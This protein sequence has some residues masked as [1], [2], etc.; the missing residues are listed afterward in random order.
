MVRAADDAIREEAPDWDPDTREWWAVALEDASP[1]DPCPDPWRCEH[2]GEPWHV[3]H[4]DY[5]RSHAMATYVKTLRNCNNFESGESRD[6]SLSVHK[7]V[8]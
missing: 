7:P 2:C 8:P 4:P 3:N 5:R 1:D 6:F